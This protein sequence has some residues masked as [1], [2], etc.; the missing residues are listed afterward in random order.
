MTRTKERKRGHQ[1][2]ERRVFVATIAVSVSVAWVADK[3][4]KLIRR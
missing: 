2:L 4:K 1:W 3:I